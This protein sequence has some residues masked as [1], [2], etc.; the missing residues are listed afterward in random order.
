MKK[1]NKR[2]D[3]NIETVVLMADK[4]YEN[5]SSSVARE[6]LKYKQDVSWILPKEIIN[7]CK[8]EWLKCWNL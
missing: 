7:E 1:V 2:I 4:E 5:M 3:S 8:K 6:L